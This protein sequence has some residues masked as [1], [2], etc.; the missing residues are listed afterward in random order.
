MLY[1]NTCWTP[2]VNDLGQWMTMD[3]GSETTIYGLVF[4]TRP[5]YQTQYVVTFT[6]AYSND[7]SSWVDVEEGR[8]FETGCQS[9]EDD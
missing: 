1:S 5:T 2:A 3:A 6:L 9:G 8:H 4:Q 7:A